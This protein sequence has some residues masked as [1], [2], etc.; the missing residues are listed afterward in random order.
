MARLS[1]P[2]PLGALRCLTVAKIS[3]SSPANWPSMARISSRSLFR[4][5]SSQAS[6]VVESFSNDGG[7]T[8]DGAAFDGKL[9]VHVQAQLEHRLGPID[10]CSGQRLAW[11][12]RGR[13]GEELA[14]CRGG[15]YGGQRHVGF[16]D[17][18]FHISES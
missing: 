4:T 12:Q 18:C 2:R 3:A 17:G 8:S 7:P 11:R 15:G 6:S 14:W 10:Q 9:Q 1:S 16:E 5:P 13:D